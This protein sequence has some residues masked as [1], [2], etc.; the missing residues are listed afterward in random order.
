MIVGFLEAHQSE[1]ALE[2]VKFAVSANLPLSV[3]L[4]Q[5]IEDGSN[6]DSKNK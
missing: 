2:I 1:R 4:L 3:E 5:K 6:L